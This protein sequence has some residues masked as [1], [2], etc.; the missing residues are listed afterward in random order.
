MRVTE[1]LYTVCVRIKDERDGVVVY[2][3]CQN[4]RR[5]T[6]WFC[7]GCVRI[8]EKRDGVAVYRV[9]QNKGRER[10]SG[11]IQGVSE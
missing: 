10:W 5:E 9:C 8:K 3:V 7:T 6:E 11:C 1:W 2:R 4:K